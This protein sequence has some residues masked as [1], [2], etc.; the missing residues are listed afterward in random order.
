VTKYWICFFFAQAGFHFLYMAGFFLLAYGLSMDE[1]GFPYWSLMY[2]TFL[3]LPPL[4][5]FYALKKAKINPLI[6]NEPISPVSV[7]EPETEQDGE[8]LFEELGE[9]KGIVNDFAEEI[10]DQSFNDLINASDQIRKRLELAADK[11][12]NQQDLCHELTNKLSFLKAMAEKKHEEITAAREVQKE[13][14]KTEER[15]LSSIAKK[16]MVDIKSSNKKT[17]IFG[18]IFSI[19]TMLL[20]HLLN[21]LMS[22]GKTF[23][24]PFPFS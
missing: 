2:T 11:V 15:H 18:V 19:L 23:N 4:S 6:D 3:V 13:L 24:N 8:S 20:G 14:K 5:S 21:Y 10:R 7:Q 9:I 22:E 17:F 16:L 1:Q 12:Q